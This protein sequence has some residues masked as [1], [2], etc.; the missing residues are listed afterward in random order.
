MS[1]FFVPRPPNA[2]ERLVGRWRR[3]RWRKHG[4]LSPRWQQMG[5]YTPDPEDR[6]P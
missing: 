6:E 2:W 4:G 3:W 5:L 1:M